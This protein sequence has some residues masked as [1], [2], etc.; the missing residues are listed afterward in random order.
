MLGLFS[1]LKMA[2]RSLQAD[3]TAVEVTGHNL[4]NADSTSYSRQRVVLESNNVIVGGVGTQGTGVR[5]ASIEQY[6]DSVLD[7]QIRQ[8][9]SV[10]GYWSTTQTALQNTQTELG[11]FLDGTSSTSDTSS[12]STSSLGL[13]SQ[14]NTLFSSFQSVASDPSSLTNRQTLVTNAQNLSR[15]FN[16]IDSRLCTINDNL[17][18]SI[19]TDVDSANKLLSTIADLNATIMRTEM[20]TGGTANDLRDAREAKLEELSKL[21]DFTATAETNGTVTVASG[22]STLVSQTAQTASLEA[23]DDG[24]G[25]MQ[26]R[27][28]NGNSMSLASGSLQGEIS[29]RDGALADLRNGLNTLASELITQVNSIYSAGYDLNGDTGANFFTGSGASDI[30][31]DSDLLADPS[32]VQVA[33]AQGAS[34]D[35]TI[36]LAL[37]QLSDQAQ[38]NLGNK[39][40]SENY[41]QLVTGL[42]NSLSGANDAVSNHDTV[43]SML[44]TQRDSA[45]G[46]SLEEEMTNLMVYQRA[47]Q[48][49]GRIISTVNTMMETLLNL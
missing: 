24:T 38:T 23:Y 19:S 13:S 8:E 15:S 16:E 7:A 39:T 11:E 17:N 46:V 33:G 27:D 36:A 4:S 34:G 12:T 3:Q 30:G 25:Q 45:S 43:S 10:G 37:A 9:A 28:S 48:A 5:V 1:T 18:K 49:S 32:L 44:S 35:N 47:Y 41:N 26:V 2:A 40:F 29:T 22:G 31:I 20:T 14:L 6:R 42:A 21:M